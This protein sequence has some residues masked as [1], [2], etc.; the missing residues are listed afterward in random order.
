MCSFHEQDEKIS[1][2]LILILNLKDPNLQT[3]NLPVAEYF[4]SFGNLLL[5]YFHAQDKKLNNK[6]RKLI[7]ILYQR[8]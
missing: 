8:D 6:L 7:I 1:K 5:L 4:F 3:H 2:P